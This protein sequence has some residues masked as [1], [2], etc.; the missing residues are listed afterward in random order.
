MWGIPLQIV[1]NDLLV[2]LYHQLS[3]LSC[4]LFS[5]FRKVLGVISDNTGTR[6][7]KM[8]MSS[9]NRSSSTAYI[10]CFEYKFTYNPGLTVCYSSGNKKQV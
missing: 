8:Q 5:I 2:H 3:I 4:L 6:P 9:M 7:I 1:A 10:A